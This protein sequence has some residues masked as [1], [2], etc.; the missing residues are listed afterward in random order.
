MTHKLTIPALRAHMG[1][2]IYYIA[3]MTMRDIAERIS[4]AEEIHTSKSLN[5]LIQRQITNR[6]AQIK[7]Y[8]LNQPQRFFNSLVIGVY[9]GS[10]QWFE[11][12]IKDNTIM[13]PDGLPNYIN[14]ALGILVLEGSEKLF[15]I[16]GQHRVVGIREAVKQDDKIG[17]E[18]VSVIFVAHYNDPAGLERTRRLFTTLNRYAKPVS[19]QEIIALD[20]DDVIAIVTRRLVEEYPLFKEKISLAKGKNIPTTDKH[21]FTT[22]VALYDALDIFLRTMRRGWNNFKKSRPNDDEIEEFYNRAK[23][24][25]DIMTAYF[26]PLEE[27]R[28]SVPAD[29]VA[30][31]YRHRE[32]GHLLFRP[33]GLLLVVK[34]LRRLIDANVSL[35]DA[36]QRI[37]KV[38]MDIAREPWVGL[39]WDAVNQ[40][41]I[42]A[43]ENQKAGIKLLFYAIGGD[44]SE[45]KTTPEELRKEL[46]GLLNV[47]EAKIEL[48]RYH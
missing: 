34:V 17:N 14:G 5:E 46:A 45:L 16:D 41:M 30:A 4:I 19:K 15:A 24:F 13:D 27:L 44:L 21:S 39:L 8:L 32:G 40:R 7:N 26:R 36:T 20:E 9:G 25:W 10:P 29:E 43:Q 35:D 37:S 33:V 38:P 31:K 11:L 1:D 6:A 23:N 3:F 48:P 2:W 28:D 18:E 42:T 22:I 12:A 47:A